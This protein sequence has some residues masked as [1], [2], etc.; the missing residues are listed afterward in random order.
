MVRQGLKR[1]PRR[2]WQRLLAACALVDRTI[3]GQEKGNPWE[4][5]RCIAV[6]MAGVRT[7]LPA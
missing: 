5:L 4:I 7:P 2:R 1:L 3:K 6:T